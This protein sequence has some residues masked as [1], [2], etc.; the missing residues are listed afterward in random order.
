MRAPVADRLG[1]RPHVRGLASDDRRGDQRGGQGGRRRARWTGSSPTRRTRSSRPTSSATRTRR[2]STRSRRWSWRARWSRSSPGTTTS[3]AT[4][5]A[6]S[7]SPPRSSSRRG[8]RCRAT[9]SKA[10][11]RDAAVEG[12]RVLVRADLNVPLDDGEVTDDT[13]IRAALPTI[14]L[15]RER[16]AA[17]VLVSHLGRPKGRDPELS[18]APVAERL[19]E[20]LDAEVELAPGVVGRRGRGA[21]PPSSSP[22]RC[23]CS[24]TPASSRARPT[25]DPELAAA[26]AALAD[27][28]VNDAFGAAHRAHATTEGVAS[29]LPAYAGLLLEREVLRA[30]RGPRRP[31]A[32]ARRRPRRRQ[33][34]RQDRRARA[35][36]RAS[37][38]R[39]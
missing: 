5:T 28:Y 26:L 8:G 31:R 38:T 9:F 20:L 33:G 13:R 10:S 7:S 15:L 25:N 1:R 36:P 35:L 32:A 19:G 39:S 21:S 18:M 37:P 27:L 14:E 30:D 6:S 3:G 12:K 22:A 23:C 24:R 29:H 16:G 2:S 11:V 4:R 34:H 17:V